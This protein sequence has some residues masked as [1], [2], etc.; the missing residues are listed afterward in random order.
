MMEERGIPR[1][2]YEILDG[3]E[4]IG[5]VTSGGMSPTLGVGIAMG[6]VPVEYKEYG[7]E[8]GIRIRKR[9]LKGKVVKHR[10]FYDD[11][12]YGWKRDK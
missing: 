10:P 11:S 3:E 6:Y 9:V 1:H 7:T 8:V 4:V 5:T 12:V 2:G